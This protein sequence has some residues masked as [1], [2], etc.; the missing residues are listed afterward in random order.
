MLEFNLRAGKDGFLA[1]NSL[2]ATAVLLTRAIGGH[3][4]DSEL[5]KTFEDLIPD[6]S[7]LLKGAVR[8]RLFGRQTV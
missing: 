7:R 3:S 5:P 4:I 6:I 2:L 1:T 8:R